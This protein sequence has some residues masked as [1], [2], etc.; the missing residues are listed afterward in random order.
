M[1]SCETARRLVF[2]AVLGALAAMPATA[3]AQEPEEPAPYSPNDLPKPEPVDLFAA[4]EAKQV[5]AQIV[6]KDHT[7]STV[8]IKNGTDRALAI[9]LPEAFLGEPV[10]G[11]WGIAG[12][13]TQAVGGGFEYASPGDRTEEN[14][15][16]K[17]VVPPG[18]EVTLKA[19]TVCLDPGLPE[20]RPD[21]PYRLRP[22]EA[23][24]QNVAVHELCKMLGR[25]GVKQTAAQAAA[26]HLDDHIPW[27]M[28]AMMRGRTGQMFSAA[29]I[30]IGKKL[31]E[32]AMKAAQKK[33]QEEAAAS[34]NKKR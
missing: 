20:P 8:R 31:A 34:G 6:P 14:G 17:V 3:P 4:I 29:D 19:K 16:P 10:A 2:L 33:R 32:E 28:L 7:R 9:R 26:W 5:E 25:D 15:G 13:R 22:I 18:K 1:A 11:N 24:S 27:P 30:R 23:H 12:V 21:V